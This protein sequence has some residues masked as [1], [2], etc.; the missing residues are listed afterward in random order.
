MELGFVE[1]FDIFLVDCLISLVARL[2]HVIG[3]LVVTCRVQDILCC[4]YVKLISNAYQNPF[5][6]EFLSP[7]NGTIDAT[8]MCSRP[9]EPYDHVV[10]RMTNRVT[11][12]S[13]ELG[14]MG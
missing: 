10:C 12:C 14:H 9:C 1:V 8:Q 2:N 5:F 3:T 6:F 11:H 4:F 13:L 7:K